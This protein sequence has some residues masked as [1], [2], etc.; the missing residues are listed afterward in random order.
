[1]CVFCFLSHSLNPSHTGLFL[2]PYF[3]HPNFLQWL[4]V[5]SAGL[6]SPT[7]ISR[8]LFLPHVS[9]QTF[10]LMS[11]LHMSLFYSTWF[12]ITEFFTTWIQICMYFC[13][14][15]LFQLLDAKLLEQSL[16][17]LCLLPWSPYLNKY[18]THVC[19]CSVTQLCLILCDSIDCNLP[20]SSV[21]RIFHPRILEWVVISSSR[22][23]SHPKD[24]IFVSCIGKADILPLNHLESPNT[25]YTSFKREKRLINKTSF[26]KEK[27]DLDSVELYT[28]KKHLIFI[29]EWE[30]N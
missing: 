14:Y 17:L 12:T 3:K 2:L 9:A 10:P 27:G 21:H 8:I 4:S 11:T 28:K 23:S 13:A 18:L 24:Q 19:I 1:M 6:L 5:L 20:C 25:W 26:R 16:Y 15:C 22:G 7:D 30:I 29:N